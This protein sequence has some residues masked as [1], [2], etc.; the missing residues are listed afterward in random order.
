[1]GPNVSLRGQKSKN[2]LKM[3]DFD[4]F[5]LLTRGQVVGRA[6][7]GGGGVQ[8]PLLILNITSNCC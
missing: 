7:N 3:A 6:S 1:M 5:F 8:M 4:H 2:L